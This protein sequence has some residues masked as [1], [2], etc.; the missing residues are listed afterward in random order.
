MTEPDM[1]IALFLAAHLDNPCGIEIDG[2][3][4]D[5]RDFYERLARK[6]LASMTNPGAKEF[7]EKKIKKEI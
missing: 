1:E 6:L 7:L 2:E 3:W 4:H 5:I